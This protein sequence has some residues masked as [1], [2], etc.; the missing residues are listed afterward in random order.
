MI[1]MIIMIIAEFSGRRG[2]SP[3]VFGGEGQSLGTKDTLSIGPVTTRRS[4]VYINSVRYIDNIY[5]K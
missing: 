3:I 2:K 5:A 4:L 1:I